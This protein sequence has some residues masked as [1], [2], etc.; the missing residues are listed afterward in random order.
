[1][2]YL[3]KM[4]LAEEFPLHRLFPLSHRRHRDQVGNI[5]LRKD[6]DL[7]PGW[8]K[9]GVP[10]RTNFYC[11]VSPQSCGKSPVSR[12]IGGVNANPGSWPWQ[13]W[14]F[15]DNSWFSTVQ[16]RKTHDFYFILFWVFRVT[17][18]ETR[19]QSPLSVWGFLFSPQIAL[20]RGSGKSFSCGGS[21]ITPE[22]VVTA[23]H[24]IS[25]GQYVH[26]Y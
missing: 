20:L 9:K 25:R 12:V 2:I 21:L 5:I 18:R 17:C 22:W 26:L 15:L 3:Y 11:V 1:M 6:S 7:S 24:C 13:V 4:V 16:L 8:E 14:L 10:N 19:L 23:A